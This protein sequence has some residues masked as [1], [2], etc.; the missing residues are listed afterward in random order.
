MSNKWIYLSSVC[1][2]HSLLQVSK[3]PLHSTCCWG[4]KLGAIFHSSFSFF[5]SR[6]CWLFQILDRIMI[7]FY[8]F[9]LYYFR[10]HHIMWHPDNSHSLLTGLPAS[11]LSTQK[12]EG[13]F[14]N[15]RQT[16]S[17]PEA[18][19]PITNPF[20]LQTSQSSTRKTPDSYNSLKTF[21]VIWL[22]S[23][24]L[25]SFS[26]TFPLPPTGQPCLPAV[27]WLFR[28]PEIFF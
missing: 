16:T 3:C 28:L 14:R 2:S 20:H 7:N 25:I 15:F 5:I 11:I 1:S 19:T 27:H 22:I 17:L 21:Y 6:F 23:M 24:A 18:D 9:Y 13:I 26:I 10:L 8:H 4:P 12:P